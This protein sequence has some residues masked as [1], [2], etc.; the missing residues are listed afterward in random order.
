M[1]WIAY[2]TIFPVHN[3]QTQAQTHT[4]YTYNTH[5]LW[6]AYETIFPVL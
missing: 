5:T 3:T 1:L 6:I 4:Q 2:E